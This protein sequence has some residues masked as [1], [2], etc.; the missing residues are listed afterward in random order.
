M[1]PADSHRI[2]RVPRYSGYCY[3]LDIFV[4][5]PF[6]FFGV[7]FQSLLL[8]IFRAILQSYY[9]NDAVTSLVWALPRSL[10]TTWGIIFYFL[11]LRVLRCFS[12][13]RLPSSLRWISILQ[14]D[15]LSHSEIF[16]SK[17]ICISPK[18]FA[19]YHVL[20]RL[21][22]PRHPPYALSYL[23]AAP[24]LLRAVSAESC[25]FFY[26]QFLVHRSLFTFFAC[27]DSFSFLISEKFIYKLLCY[28]EEF[29]LLSNMS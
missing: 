28:Q 16:G 2:P 20:H 29:S 5:Q 23:F 14:M 7:I 1:V 26:L 21:Q 15:R 11:F 24:R 18:L 22:E 27:F 17:I 3:A 8:D 9:P 19:A 13:P 12:S 6:T 10:A 25:T 4:Y